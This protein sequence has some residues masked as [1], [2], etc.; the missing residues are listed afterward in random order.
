MRTARIPNQPFW[1]ALHLASGIS[2]EGIV[3]RRL[4]E[5]VVAV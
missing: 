2:K 5:S 4:I 1:T 3:L